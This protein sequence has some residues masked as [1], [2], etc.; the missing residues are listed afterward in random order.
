MSP[1]TSTTATA[2]SSIVVEAPIDLAFRVFTE[3]IG[4]WF[5]S[6]YN[7]M[8]SRIATRTFEPW[9]G[10]QIVDRSETGAEC[11]WSR[12]LAY[13]PPDRVVFSWDI[14][15]WWTIET[16]PERTSEVEVR[17]ISETEART[18]VELVH[19]HLDRHGEGWQQLR[20]AIAGDGGWTGCLQAFARLAE[21]Q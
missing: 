5:P 19:R 4:S 15:P 16:D 8:A 2:T 11:R 14:S 13:E 20:D 3:E 6:E 21:A 18:R 10:G 9:V 7:L 12:V 1:E 17:F